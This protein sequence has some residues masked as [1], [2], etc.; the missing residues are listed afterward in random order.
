M[1]IHL[2]SVYIIVTQEGPLVIPKRLKVNCLHY[3][4]LKS[5]PDSKPELSSRLKNT[6]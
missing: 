5:E 4:A 2:I 6:K 1:W 3:T